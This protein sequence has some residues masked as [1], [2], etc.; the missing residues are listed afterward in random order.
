M[1]TISFQCP[2]CGQPYEGSSEDIGSQAECASC[3][4]AFEIEAGSVTVAGKARPNGLQCYLRALRRYF[5]FRGRMGR[6]EFCWTA[7][8]EA[9]AL[10]V[11]FV[12]DLATGADKGLIYVFAI[13]TVFPAFAAVARRLHDTDKS[14]WRVFLAV[15]PVLN[16]ALFAWLVQKGDSG[17][18]RFGADPK[19]S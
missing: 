4:R 16:L 18:N 6:R 8:F 15:M 2:H 7:V 10:F 19:V 3:G 9:A 5:G 1:S 14:G 13:A 17:P 11:V 12:A